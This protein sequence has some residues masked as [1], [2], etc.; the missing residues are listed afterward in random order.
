MLCAISE[1]QYTTSDGLPPKER[2]EDLDQER[3]EWLSWAIG[4]NGYASQA[5][6]WFNP[7][8]AMQFMEGRAQVFLVSERIVE[9]PFA[10]QAL[11]ELPV[12]SHVLDVGGSES[13]VGLSLAS[14]GH[15]VA[16]VD[17]RRDIL[18]H[19]SLIHHP[20]RLA[21]L[22]PPRR[23]YDAVLALSAVEH[24][25]LGHYGVEAGDTREDLDA[26]RRLR[27]LVHPEGTLVLTVPFGDAQVD[28][29]Q[30]VYDESGLAELLE[31]WEVVRSLRAARRDREVW[32]VGQP[33]RKGEHGVA[34]IAARP[35]G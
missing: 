7:P 13:T 17:P 27:E 31:G 5:G 29:F 8:V 6:A 34:L 4:P 14:L 16:V 35:A 24:F 2:L 33:W 22:P 9:Q 20:Y 30:R 32:L 12:G 18:R 21:D 25:G 11:A 28:D 19:P 10:F 3:A 23:P 26:M 15:H 1:H